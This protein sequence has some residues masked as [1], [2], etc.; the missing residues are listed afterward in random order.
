MSPERLR[1]FFNKAEGGYRI[2]KE[3]RD[4]CVFARQDVTRDPP[5][6]KLDLVVCRN[7]LIYLNQ[8]TQRKVLGILHYALRPNGV[9]MLGGSE[10]IGS[11]AEL[12]AT[13]AKK[14]QLYRKKGD[15]DVPRWNRYPGGAAGRRPYRPSRSAPKAPG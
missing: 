12:F 15:G 10:S 6:S 4:R 1:R 9:L 14:Y 5:F 2:S 8:A 7:L 3:V 13:F 11:R